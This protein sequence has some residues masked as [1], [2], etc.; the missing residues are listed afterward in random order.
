MLCDACSRADYLLQLRGC[1]S[2][3]QASMSDADFLMQ[4]MEFRE[5]LENAALTRSPQELSTLCAEIAQHSTKMEQDFERAY[6][7]GLLDA[8]QS[9]VA[10]MRF[11]KKLKYEA[12][13]LAVAQDSA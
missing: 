9:L 10:Q 12:K 13:A 11:M 3:A 6:A 1:T 7:A 8:A 4:Q 2:D 5:R